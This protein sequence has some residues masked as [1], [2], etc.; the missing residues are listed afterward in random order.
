MDAGWKD[1]V[2]LRPAEDVEVLVRFPDLPGRY[3]MH[4]HN[5]EHEDMM[6]MATIEIR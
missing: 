1:T 5:L 6:M 4:C 2:D 3:V